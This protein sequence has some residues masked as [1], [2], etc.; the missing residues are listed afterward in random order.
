MQASGWVTT[1]DFLQATHTKRVPTTT[2]PP[3]YKQKQLMTIIVAGLHSI[4]KKKV[5]SH[6]TIQEPQA[7]IVIKDTLRLWHERPSHKNIM[8]IINSTFY[9][10]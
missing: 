2:V 8:Y 3:P 7:N 4:K 10:T 9:K 1:R 5:S 6:N